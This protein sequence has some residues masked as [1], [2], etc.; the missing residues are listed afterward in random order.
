MR[1]IPAIVAL[2]L[3]LGLLLPPPVLGQGGIGPG[4]VIN[5]IDADADGSVSRDEYIAARDRNFERYDRNGDGSLDVGDFPRASDYRRALG[6]I[7]DRIKDADKNGDGLLSRAEM[8]DAP[9]V[10]FDRADTSRDGYLSRNEITA[11]RKA[12]MSTPR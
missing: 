2:G 7:E 11:A 12:F 3:G 9:T 10:I 8:H 4:V 6:R 5:D 1:A